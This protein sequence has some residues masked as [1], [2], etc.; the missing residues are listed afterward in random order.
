MKFR[1]ITISLIIFFLLSGMDGAHGQISYQSNSNTLKKDNVSEKS[2][3]DRQIEYIKKLYS[4]KIEDPMDFLNG[5][6]YE[7]YYTRSKSKPILYGDKRRTATIFTSSRTYKNLNL[8]YDTFLDEVIYTDISKTINFTF[9]Q[10]ALNRNLIEG[11]NFYFDDDSLHFRHL[12]EPECSAKNLTEGYYEI[13]YQGGVTYV[14]KH[15]S[16]F[17]VREGMNE[18]N[19]SPENYMS[20]GDKFYRIRSKDDLLKLLSAKSAEMKKY[21]HLARIRIRQ[22][23]KNQFIEI[24]KHYESL[25]T[26]SR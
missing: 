21:L 24:L 4:E 3:T 16:S 12:R 18:Y 26:A 9:P 15:K 13:A 10:I 17:Y 8:Q 11:F 20:L 14:I 22:A 19:Y 1:G 25:V 5:K 7:S 2:I 23:D 6:E